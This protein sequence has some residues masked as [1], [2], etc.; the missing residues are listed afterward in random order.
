M[1]GQGVFLVLKFTLKK[2]GSETVIEILKVNYNTD[3]KIDLL[4]QI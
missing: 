3:L 1:N 4:F 2:K